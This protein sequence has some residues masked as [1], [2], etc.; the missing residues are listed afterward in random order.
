VGE[1]WMLCPK[2][3]E[4]E[5][6]IGKIN[7]RIA[8]ESQIIGDEVAPFMCPSCGYIELYNKKKLVRV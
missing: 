7:L 2:C 3:N 4:A 1:K 8:T 5:M 6:V